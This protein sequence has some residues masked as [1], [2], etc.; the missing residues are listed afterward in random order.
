MKCPHCLV[1]VNPN[2]N[3]IPIGNDQEGYWSAFTMNCPN[4][5]CKK[6]I[7]DL[8]SGEVPLNRVC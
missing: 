1:E 7:V 4:E 5:K 8:A 6:L 3:E 2:Y